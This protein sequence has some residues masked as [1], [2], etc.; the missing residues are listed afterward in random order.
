VCKKSDAICKTSEKEYKKIT[1]VNKRYYFSILKKKEIVAQKVCI[2]YIHR[3][4]CW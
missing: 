4:G 3:K 1:K 2:V